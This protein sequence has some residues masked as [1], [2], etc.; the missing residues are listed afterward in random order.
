[1]HASYN[2]SSLKKVL[3]EHSA[4][5]MRKAVD[6]LAKR[7]EKHFSIDDDTASAQESAE[8]VN[9]VWRACGKEL[10]R[11]TERE[12]ELISRCFADSGLALEYSKA[13]VEGAFKRTK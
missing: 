7:V 5:D 1:M 9:A 3:K 12:Q 2:K 4:K 8:M 13:D 11:E 10:A 6:A